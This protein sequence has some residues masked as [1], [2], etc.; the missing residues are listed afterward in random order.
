MCKRPHGKLYIIG[1]VFQLSFNKLL[2]NNDSKD[3]FFFY[4]RFCV[5]K[6][7]KNNKIL[8]SITLKSN[9]WQSDHKDLYIVWKVWNYAF[10]KM[11]LQK[12]LSAKTY[13]TVEICVQEN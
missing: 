2:E 3:S 13:N 5:R 11:S 7:W 6:T 9:I 1:K 12:Y 10:R 8:Y 4:F